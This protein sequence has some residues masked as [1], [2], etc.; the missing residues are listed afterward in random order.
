MFLRY[1]VRRGNPLWASQRTAKETAR[2]DSCVTIVGYRGNSVYR[3]V[4]SIPVWVTCGRFPWK[5]PTAC[6]PY[7]MT[8]ALS[9]IKF[10]SKVTPI[11]SKVICRVYNTQNH[12]RTKY[13]KLDV[14]HWLS[15]E[16]KY[17]RWSTEL[18]YSAPAKLKHLEGNP[19][20]E[21]TR[22]FVDVVHTLCRVIAPLLLNGLLLQGIGS[23]IQSEGHVTIYSQL[24][25][26]VFSRI[27]TH[28]QIS[29]S[30]RHLWFG[31]CDTH[32]LK[33]GRV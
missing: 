19:Q 31:P 20:A 17:Y 33:K 8:S 21:K 22:I 7:R 23:I 12:T 13:G 3:V 18:A 26:L 29:V 2:N 25:F 10:C 27:W 14:N 6:S 11:R 30:L 32:S 1:S 15:R 9:H 16:L 4:A 24:V 5:A 28:D